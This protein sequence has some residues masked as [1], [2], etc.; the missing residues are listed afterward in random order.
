MHVRAPKSHTLSACDACTGCS[1]DPKNRPGRFADKTGRN[2][3]GLPVRLALKPRTAVA[4]AEPCMFTDGG[5]AKHQ[6]G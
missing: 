3:G 1:S 6:P 4:V 5:G 2:L